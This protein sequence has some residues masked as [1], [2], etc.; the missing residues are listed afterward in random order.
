MLDSLQLTSEGHTR[1]LALALALS[2][3][4]P[5]VPLMYPENILAPFSPFIHTA[6]RAKEPIWPLPPPDTASAAAAPA[7][8]SAPSFLVRPQCAHR[9]QSSAIVRGGNEKVAFY[10][11]HITCRW[12]VCF[13]R[14][15][16]NT[17]I[18]ILWPTR[19]V[20]ELRLRGAAF[21]YP[22]LFLARI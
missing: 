4:P 12:F 1:S 7:A 15:H 2:P 20:T 8:A 14:S 19:K 3:P 21:L 13:G 9:S 18:S 16:Y 10:F 5:P 17:T 6:G 11:E 22:T